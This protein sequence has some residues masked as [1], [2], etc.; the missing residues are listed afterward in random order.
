MQHSDNIHSCLA[1][2]AHIK[3]QIEGHET[4]TTPSDGLFL[5]QNMRPY[6]FH[7]CIIANASTEL[8]TLFKMSDTNKLM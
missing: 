8:S 6:I 4:L 2:N 1:N 7:T 3:I 5:T